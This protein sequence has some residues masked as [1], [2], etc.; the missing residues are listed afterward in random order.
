MKL[1][2]K[3]MKLMVAAIAA[4]AMVTIVADQAHAE[5]SGEARVHVDQA[6]C[7][8]AEWTNKTFKAR[9]LCQ[10]YSTVHGRVDVKNRGDRYFWF[11][12]GYHGGWMTHTLS[13]GIRKID[14]CWDKG[15]CFENEVEP[16]SWG[17]IRFKSAGEFGAHKITDHQDSC[18]FCARYPDTLY[19]TQTHDPSWCE[20]GADGALCGG[21]ICQSADCQEAF[22]SS[23]AANSC[24]VTGRTYVDNMCVILANCEGY[25]GE[26]S[27]G[28]VS[29]VDLYHMHNC[30]G[31]LGVGEC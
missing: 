3:L 29:V 17:W 20:S 26:Q 24:Q 7:L 23:S 27:T 21:E 14:C 31:V 28:K 25:S 8:E 1:N 18:G 6:T 10:D 16:D 2:A 11:G 12:K 22:E 30:N 5:C 13:N 19:C 9:S 15:M 4:L